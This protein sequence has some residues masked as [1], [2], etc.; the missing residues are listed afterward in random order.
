MLR[1]KFLLYRVDIYFFILSYDGLI[2][3]YI[4]LIVYKQITNSFKK[5][6]ILHTF[7]IISS[8]LRSHIVNLFMGP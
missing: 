1:R 3:F 8:I 6:I 7:K 5:Q 2:C 4:I